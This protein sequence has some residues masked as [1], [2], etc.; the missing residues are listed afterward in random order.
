MD[1]RPGGGEFDRLQDDLRTAGRAAYLDHRWDVDVLDLV[2]DSIVDTP[3]GLS[4]EV[5]SLRFVGR[6]C[7]VDVDLHGYRRVTPGLRVSPTGPVVVETRT[8]GVHGPRTTL[9][10]QANATIWVRPQLT[11]FLLRWPGSDR[12]P[13]R[14]A[15]VLL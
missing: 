2:F 8:W 13:A 11:S 15:W 9:W 12:P 6:G 7:T 14:T 3:G 4:G 10:S 5:R 1:G